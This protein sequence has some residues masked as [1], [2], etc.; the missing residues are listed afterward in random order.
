MSVLVLSDADVHAQFL[1]GHGTHPDHCSG[2]P[3]DSEQPLHHRRADAHAHD[4]GRGSAAPL[5]LP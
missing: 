4:L 5:T 3:L 2:P 1:A